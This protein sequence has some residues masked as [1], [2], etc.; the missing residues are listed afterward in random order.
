MESNKKPYGCTLY[1][2]MLLRSVY[3]LDLIISNTEMSMAGVLLYYND[4]WKEPVR[5]I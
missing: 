5:E 3:I 1:N 4:K 2:Y